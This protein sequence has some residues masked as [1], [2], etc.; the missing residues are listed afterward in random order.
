MY[1]NPL[2]S[3]Q[4][5]GRENYQIVYRIQVKRFI[6]RVSITDCLFDFFT[7][8]RCNS[9]GT[10]IPKQW[11][12]DTDVDCPDR[13][14]ELFCNQTTCDTWMFEC[15]DGNCIYKTWTCDGDKDC[16]NGKDEENCKVPPSNARPTEPPSAPNGQ[17]H[18]WMFKCANS[19]CV[20]DW[21][22]CDGVN[23]CGD[24]SDEMGCKNS[25]APLTTPKPMTEKPKTDKCKQYQFH[26]DSGECISKRFVCDGTPDCANGEDERGC[27][28]ESKKK[29][30]PGKFRC[31]S[32]GFCLPIEKYCDKVKNCVDNSDEMYC[33]HHWQNQTANVPVSCKAGMFYCDN[34]CLPLSVLCNNKMDCQDGMDES[35]CNSTSRIYQVNKRCVGLLNLQY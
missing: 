6:V 17:C 34:T 3:E 7:L 23:D 5:M 29:C 27:P 30:G 10:C 12:C 8:I 16:P 22:K 28:S 20:P 19:K 18:D 9:T 2:V 31:I 11:R 13:T 26:C 14:D 21:W 4:L 15:G 35:N 24:N 33:E 25:T 1:A 32:D